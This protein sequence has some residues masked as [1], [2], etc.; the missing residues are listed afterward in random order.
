MKDKKNSTKNV[1]FQSQIFWCKKCNIPIITENNSTEI[2]PICGEKISYLSSDIRPV[3]PQER[4]LL[5]ILKKKPLEFINSSVWCSNNNYY[6]DGKKISVSNKELLTADIESIKAKLNELSSKN[7]E[8]YFTN[9][10]NKFCI[11]NKDRLVKITDEASNFIIESASNY[12]PENL[13]I[14]FSGGKDSTV[15]ADLV[16]RALGT[17]SIVHIFGNTTVE[18]PSTISYA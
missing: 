11:A 9:Y 15:T 2:C 10:I 6:I 17:R 3:F 18:F 7:K 14:S 16:T 1:P 4:L 12:P 13:I 8:I 5:E